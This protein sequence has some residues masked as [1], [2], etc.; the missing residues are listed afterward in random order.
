MHA[1]FRHLGFLQP[2]GVPTKA[3]AD[4]K[5]FAAAHG[6]LPRVLL[7]GDSI[8]MGY[9]D[10]VARLLEGKAVVTRPATNCGDTTN[11]LRHLEEWLDEPMS[12]PFWDVIHWNFGL[13]DLCYRHPESTAYGHRDKQRGT[14]SVP[15]ERYELNLDIIA[16]RLRM[17]RDDTMAKPIMATTTIVP[18]GEVGRIAGDEVTYNAVAKKIMAKHGIPVNDLHALTAGGAKWAMLPQPTTHG[19]FV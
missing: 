9:G 2:A 8:S 17:I 5:A 1:G 7:L 13:H 3:A 12:L 15:L 4:V 19:H 14:V 6:A 16:S 18:S 10:K 11:A